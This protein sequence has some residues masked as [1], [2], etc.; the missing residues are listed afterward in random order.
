VN[1]GTWYI[2]RQIGDAWTVPMVSEHLSSGTAAAA[3]GRRPRD[4]SVDSASSRARR[5]ALVAEC[6]C[7][8]ADGHGPDRV[9][10]PRPAAALSRAVERFA[11]QQVSRQES[12]K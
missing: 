2:R 1:R 7:V 11:E 6:R 12:A 3:V 4:W 10:R 8:Y 5:S 9:A